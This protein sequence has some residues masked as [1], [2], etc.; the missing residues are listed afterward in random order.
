MFSFYSAYSF[1]N[2]LPASEFVVEVCGEQKSVKL[3]HAFLKCLSEWG[4]TLGQADGL[5]L[6]PEG[7]LLPQLQDH[8]VVRHR[9]VRRGPVPVRDH[10]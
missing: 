5:D 10:L 7:D 6:V 1:M 2:F 9:G 3:C 8:E 4:I